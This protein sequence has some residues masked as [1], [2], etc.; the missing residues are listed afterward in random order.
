MWAKTD[1]PLQFF[2][3]CPSCFHLF[4]FACFTWHIA[5]IIWSVCEVNWFVLLRTSAQRWPAALCAG[6]LTCFNQA[7]KCGCAFGGRMKHPVMLS[8]WGGHLLVTKR[9]DPYKMRLRMNTFMQMCSVL[10]QTACC[11]RIGSLQW[12]GRFL[13]FL[14]IVFC[15]SFASALNLRFDLIL[16]G[17]GWSEL[18]RRAYYWM[19]W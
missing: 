14:S 19:E 11:G 6:V 18:V 1:E 12:V 4:M 9:E 17:G 3:S 16:D 13:C 10:L 2:S 7:S 8:V 5:S 15:A